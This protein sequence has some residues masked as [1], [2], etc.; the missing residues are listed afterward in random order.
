VVDETI[1]PVLELPPTT[2][3]TSHVTAVLTELVE[4]VFERLTTAVK[5]V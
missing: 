3:F 4:V 5:S 1:V 2:P